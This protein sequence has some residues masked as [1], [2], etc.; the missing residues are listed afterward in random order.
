MVKG[1][2]T[3]AK[4]AAL[5]P[6]GFAS[7]ILGENSSISIRP[8]RIICVEALCRYVLCSMCLRSSQ[9]RNR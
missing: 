4:A 7:E 5:S 2:C 1:S 8:R 6:A 9:R 3:T